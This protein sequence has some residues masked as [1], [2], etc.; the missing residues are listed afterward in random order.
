MKKIEKDYLFALYKRVMKK[1]RDA[2]LELVEM[3]NQYFPRSGISKDEK[4]AGSS[5][6]R[7]NL[8]LMYLHLMRKT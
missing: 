8:H 1:E 2:E 5:H 3:H 7:T 4:V 6:Y